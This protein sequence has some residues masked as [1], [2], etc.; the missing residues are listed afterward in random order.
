M[1]PAQSF[2]CFEG[3]LITGLMSL[4]ADIQEGLELG[5]T[6]A[7]EDRAARKSVSA[8]EGSALG[9]EKTRGC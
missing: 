9:G 3:D 5:W 6:P 7:C 2:N 4:A 1:N 8:P